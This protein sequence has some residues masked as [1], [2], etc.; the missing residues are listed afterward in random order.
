MCEAGRWDPQQQHNQQQPHG[1]ADEGAHH[2]RG[3]CAR[4][5]HDGAQGEKDRAQ[6]IS[7]TS[8]SASAAAA[9]PTIILISPDDVVAV[10][11]TSSAGG[12]E[13]AGAGGE[14]MGGEEKASEQV[15]FPS[16]V[17]QCGVIEYPSKGDVKGV[18]WKFIRYIAPVRGV[19]RQSEE[20]RE[21]N[22]TV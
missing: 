13:A 7:Q 10:K 19:F 6:E 15:W 11:P 22:K 3:V 21:R 16:V 1:R 2:G 4:R 17:I 8:A 5:L 12:T 9:A 20:R 14:G 18:G